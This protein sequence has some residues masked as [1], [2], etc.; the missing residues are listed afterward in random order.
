MELLLTYLPIIKL[1]L[2]SIAVYACIDH[3]T[4]GARLFRGYKNAKQAE[5]YAQNDGTV[6]YL[7][8]FW[9]KRWIPYVVFAVYTMWLAIQIS[10]YNGLT[11]VKV[12]LIC[13]TYYW[14]RGNSPREVFPAGKGGKWKDSLRGITSGAILGLKGLAPIAI[15]VVDQ[16]LLLLTLLFALPLGLYHWFFRGSPLFRSYGEL[17]QGGLI[18]APCVLLNLYF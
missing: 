8:Y 7:T 13:A 11:L 3:W 2:L 18:I 12:I 6:G 5:D 10:G 9:D 14:F 16:P 4:G 15:R 1:S 17:C